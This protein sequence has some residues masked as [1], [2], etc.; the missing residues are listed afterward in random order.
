[1]RLDRMLK[2]IVS[3]IF[4]YVIKCTAILDVWS[5]KQKQNYLMEYQKKNM[6]LDDIV[7][8]KLKLHCRS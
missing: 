4:I 2:R 1:M 3:L 6:I 5:V 8:N 7:I